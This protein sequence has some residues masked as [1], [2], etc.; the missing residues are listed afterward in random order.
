MKKKYL[1]K[2]GF[3]KQ[4]GIALITVMVVLFVLTLLGLAATD[5]SNFQALMVRNNQFRLETF[6]V[7]RAE[8]QD[9]LVALNQ[10][11]AVGAPPLAP[12]VILG[13]DGLPAEAGVI[14][15]ADS[16]SARALFF[17]IDSGGQRLSTKDG[18]N[19]TTFDVL[20]LNQGINQDVAFRSVRECAVDGGSTGEAI[21]SGIRCYVIQVDS[22]AQ[23]TGTNIQ[24]LQ[25]QTI[26]FN[27]F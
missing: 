13:N 9:Q 1:M 6:N 19:G 10:A 16:E 4:Q 18:S 25:S 20:S 27:S 8:I 14:A 22:D 23:L 2:T 12:G 24:S 26:E 5:S 17:A 7:S 15:V 21:A 3:E 11:P